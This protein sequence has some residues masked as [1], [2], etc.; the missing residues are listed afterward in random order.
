MRRP[1]WRLAW[2]TAL[3]GLALLAGCGGCSHG[4]GVGT[5][6][7]PSGVAAL[8]PR[9]GRV[10]VRAVWVARTHYRTPADIA[11][12]MHNCAAV[13]ANTVLWQVRGEGTV[14]YPSALEPWAAQYEYRDPGFDPL[15]VAV[16]EAG[17]CGL[18][19]E[20]WVNVMP[21]WKGD[22]PPP[23]GNQLYYAHPGWFLYDAQGR[24]QA[25]NDQYVSLNPCDPEVRSHIVALCRELATRYAIDGIHLD[26][27]RYAWDKTPNALKRFPRD[28]RT[29]ALFRQETGRRPDDD[30]PA[31]NAWRAEQI[32]R[33]V[34]D[35]RA[36]LR[37]TQP[38]CTLTAAVRS[39][40]QAAYNDC[41]Q[42]AV[43]WARAGLVD[44]LM[45]MAYTA[46]P[47]EF[48]QD[49]TAYRWACPGVRIVPGVGLY[50]LHDAGALRSELQQ[51]RAWGGDM[52]LFSC[53]SL[54][55]SATGGRQGA[56]QVEQ[57]MRRQVLSEFVHPLTANR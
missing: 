3:S 28:A 32:T 15:A 31:W 38:G 44:A 49:V 52:A 10:P 47:G 29:V 36:M 50:L 27:V 41:L 33:L 18:R 46:S 6:A 12:I 57:Q 11:A 48:A 53:E 23:I 42:D 7:P 2:A 1:A 22:K 14:T 43:G 13:G 24:R 39:N 21:G 8:P 45:P 54:F 55:P 37:A 51:C 40:P 4:P 56:E 35:I 5:G 20:A 19:I 16:Q 25:L 34:A 17:R 9:T 30:P 26:Y